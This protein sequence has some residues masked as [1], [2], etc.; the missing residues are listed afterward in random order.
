MINPAPS[1]Q[2]AARRTSTPERR[3]PHRAVR[4]AEQ[5]AAECGVRRST[6]FVQ[7]SVAA[8]RGCREG[9]AEGATRMASKATGPNRCERVRVE[10]RELDEVPR[11][12]RPRIATRTRT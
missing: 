4:A 8:H 7:R 10:A 5:E 6:P 1:L 9:G 12:T 2:A 3:Q 11:P